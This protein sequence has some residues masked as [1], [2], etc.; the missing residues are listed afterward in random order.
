MN[1]R[2]GGKD[3]LRISRKMGIQYRFVSLLYSLNNDMNIFKRLQLL[4]KMARKEVIRKG[5]RRQKEGKE[6]E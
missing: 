6:V 2:R 3:Y 1:G 4:S 5:L